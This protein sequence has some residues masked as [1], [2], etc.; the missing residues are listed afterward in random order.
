MVTVHPR[1]PPARSC[2]GQEQTELCPGT[3]CWKTWLPRLQARTPRAST[4]TARCQDFSSSSH[5]LLWP[6]ARPGLG[7]PPAASPWCPGR[8]QLQAA[9]QP[10][11]SSGHRTSSPGRRG[12]EGARVPS[13]QAQAVLSPAD[14]ISCCRTPCSAPAWYRGHGGRAH[15]QPSNRACKVDGWN[16]VTKQGD[17]VI[18][19]AI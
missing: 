5:A 8:A 9:A 3:S 2:P 12:P 14:T 10:G 1:C 11:S 4:N 15:H 13:R 7:F 18:K 17:P 6:P 16:C 19:P